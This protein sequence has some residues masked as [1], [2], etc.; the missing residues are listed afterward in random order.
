MGRLEEALAAY[1]AAVQQFPAD[2]VPVNGR[3]ETLRSMGRLEEALAAYDAAVE[4]FP[5][6][7]Y[8]ITGRAGTLRSMGRLEEALAA[9][10]A[11]VLAHP[12]NPSA[13]LGRAGV[14]STMNRLTEA[15]ASYEHIER[16]LPYE[17]FARLRATS[18]RAVLGT[19]PGDD[20]VDADSYEIGAYGCATAT[21]NGLLRL[22]KGD[23]SGAEAR[24]RR[25]AGLAVD[26]SQRSLIE[27]CQAVERLHERDYGAAAALAVA[28]N[29]QLGFGTWKVVHEH[30]S[31]GA[32]SE[33]AAHETVA[34]DQEE[35]RVSPRE[36]RLLGTLSHLREQPMPS[37]ELEAQIVR[38]EIDLLLLAA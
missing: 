30:A 18:L 8:P 15:L 37:P 11:A 33:S 7:P 34:V 23:R 12:L 6:N 32:K 13:L 36:E 31:L 26:H 29:Y 21:V 28:P 5:W 17:R 24:F 16:D 1:D 22:R 14:L 10:D 19:E 3:A 25:G 2:P 38:E 27:L 20:G 9:Y 35:P 4:Q